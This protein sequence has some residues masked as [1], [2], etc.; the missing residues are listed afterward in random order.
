MIF[1]KLNIIKNN[2]KEAQIGKD[3][4]NNEFPIIKNL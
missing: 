1:L 4:L 2:K 3:I